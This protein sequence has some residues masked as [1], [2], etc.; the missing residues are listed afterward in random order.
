MLTNV[1]MVYMWSNWMFKKLVKDS[2]LD[3][4]LV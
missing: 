2:N 3:D 4:V 1:K